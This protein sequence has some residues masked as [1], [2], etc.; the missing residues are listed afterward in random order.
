MKRLILGMTIVCCLTVVSGAAWC[1]DN[2]N[3]T[4][5][6]GDKP[7]VTMK[8]APTVLSIAKVDDQTPAVAVP[9]A[10]LSIYTATETATTPG[11][12]VTSVTTDAN[13]LAEVSGVLSVGAWYMIKETGT[14]DGNVTAPDYGPF[15]MQATSP[16]TVTMVDNRT[17]FSVA[18]RDARTKAK[19]GGATLV[20][21]DSKVVN[22]ETVPDTA[23]AH[24]CGTA[25][26]G[27]GRRGPGRRSP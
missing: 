24:S 1:G 23:S 15:Q 8:D 18:K 20:I 27:D 11:T 19:M 7:T 13:G 16:T 4:V 5:T 14:P 12:F 10:E 25:A 26:S 2:G 22:G 9:G 21:Y 3:G 6:D 17:V